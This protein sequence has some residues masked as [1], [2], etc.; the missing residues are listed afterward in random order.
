M[1]EYKEGDKL[2][3]YGHTDEFFTEGE[4]YEVI[5]VD[6]YGVSV[7]D[8]DGDSHSL[9]FGFI[10]RYFELVTEP[11]P[12]VPARTSLFGRTPEVG[13]V[14][15]LHISEECPEVNGRTGVVTD[16]DEDGY[17][18]VDIPSE[19]Y[20]GYTFVDPNTDGYEIN[21]KEPVKASDNVNSPQHYTQGNIEVIDYIDQVADGYVG[22]QA[23]YAGNVIKY[24]SRAP[25]KNQ[26]QDIR[27]AIWYAERLADA[28]E[29]PE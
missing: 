2:I 20:G 3:H 21:P 16:V 25:Y 19:D 1:A 12:D 29:A 5:Y 17:F 8:D 22:K 14:V 15:K 24:V 7:L 6:K 9:G 18:D 11:Q 26:A 27:K 10:P 23:V 4:S 13:D 28:M